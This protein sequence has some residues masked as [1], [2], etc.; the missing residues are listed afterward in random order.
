M[1]FPGIEKCIVRRCTEASEE[2]LSRKD[3]HFLLLLGVR[4]CVCTAS[5][6]NTSPVKALARLLP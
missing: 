5:T 4:S 6:M 3:F 2:D 1:L